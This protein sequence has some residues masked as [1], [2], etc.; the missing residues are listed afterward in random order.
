MLGQVV[1]P[2]EVSLVIGFPVT[3]DEWEA[4]AGNPDAEMPHRALTWSDYCRHIAGPVSLAVTDARELGARVVTYAGV[5]CLA[6]AAA[7]SRVVILF[8]HQN[9]TPSIEFR[10]G[11]IP[12]AKA[13]AMFPPSF[14]GIVDAAACSTMELPR[15]IRARS[16]KA[17]VRGRVE[18]L[19]C[20]R[21][22]RRVRLTLVALACRT[23]TYEDAAGLA[24]ESLLTG[25]DPCL[26]RSLAREEPR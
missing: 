25:R 7:V 15:L 4:G 23:T 26:G 24:D 8:S 10:E 16:P 19:N 17:N 14:D 11:M 21:E 6:E 18:K 3:K 5:G 2:S 9:C 22:A 20:D 12:V 1:R 13:A